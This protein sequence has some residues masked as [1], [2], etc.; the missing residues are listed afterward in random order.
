MLGTASPATTVDWRRPRACSP[1]LSPLD[2]VRILRHPE[3]VPG[4]VVVRQKLTIINLDPPAQ[5]QP[6]PRIYPS[7]FSW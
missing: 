7:A 6:Q 2:V 5:R 3:A 4:T 1:S